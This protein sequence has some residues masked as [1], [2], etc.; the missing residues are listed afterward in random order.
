M[1]PIYNSSCLQY[2]TRTFYVHDLFIDLYLVLNFRIYKHENQQSKVLCVNE[3][4]CE[5]NDSI[6]EQ[7]IMTEAKHFV[8]RLIISRV[9]L[10]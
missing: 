1:I 6:L 10:V 5:K 7:C 3:A 2:A 8:R 9:L 4:K